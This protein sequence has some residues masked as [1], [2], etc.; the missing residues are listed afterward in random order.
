MDL[1]DDGHL[2]AG[3]HLDAVVGHGQRQL[4]QVERLSGNVE[5]HD[6][7]HA[8]AGLLLAIGEAGE[9]N[10]AGQGPVAL[11]HEIG[12]GLQRLELERKVEKGLPRGRAERRMQLEL[13][14]Q[15]AQGMIV[16]IRH[17]GSRHQ[18]GSAMNSRS[19]MPG[20]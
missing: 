10:R 12:S 2:A 14:H 15:T 5:R 8:L 17:R 20:I 7:A 4:L 6:L 1:L 16:E 18:G 13:P 11:A 3:Q 19:L 9:Q